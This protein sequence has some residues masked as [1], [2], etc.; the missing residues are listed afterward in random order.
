MFMVVDRQRK[1]EFY[2]RETRVETRKTGI[3]GQFKV[4]AGPIDNKRQ[5]LTV[6]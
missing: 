2:G 3:R 4:F 6:T 5:V 1:S